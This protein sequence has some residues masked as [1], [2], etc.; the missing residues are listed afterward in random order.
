[1]VG[2]IAVLAAL[3]SWQ[4]LGAVR[5]DRIEP[6]RVR[7]GQRAVIQGRGFS[8]DPEANVVLFEDKRARVLA[9]TAARLEVE[10]PEAVAEAGFERSVS[11]RVQRGSRASE[12]ITVLVLQGPRVHALSPQAAMPGEEVLLAGA[13]LGPGAN[14]RFGEALAQIVQAEATR[15]RVVVPELGRVARRHRSS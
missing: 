6:A 5:V 7:V 14:V 2:V 12:P 9:A 3:A 8:T 4:I 11:L 10:V 13:G 1:M 15:I